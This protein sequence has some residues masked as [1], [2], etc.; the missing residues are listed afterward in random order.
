MRHVFRLGAIFLLFYLISCASVQPQKYRTC[1]RVI[2]GDTIELDHNEKVRL[3]GI[4]T[5]ETVDPRKPVQRFGIEAS[6]FTN[7]LVSGRAVRLEYDQDKSDKYFRT[8]AYVYLADGTFVNAEIIK[9]GF[10]FAYTKYPFKYLD[11]FRSLERE[12][13]E[14]QT[15]LWGDDNHTT[16]NITSATQEDEIVY[17][18][19]SGSKYHTETCS[20]LRKS[21]IPIKLK[22]AC[23]RGY[24]PCSRCD[25][26]PCSSSENEGDDDQDVTVY[27]TKSGSKYHTEACG[28]LRKTKIPIKLKD[29]C[30][31]GY[32]PCSRCSP[33]PCPKSEKEAGGAGRSQAPQID[34][35]PMANMRLIMKTPQKEVYSHALQ[36]HHQR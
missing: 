36:G 3:I 23:A 18:T 26:P 16:R 33:P 22:D 7:K 14:S 5:P 10:A 17:V 12:A 1:T 30:D 2:D 9:Q 32:S 4:D 25:P 6:E 21:K 27:I 20:S 31:R 8:L 11:K 34:R 13:R 15:G 35:T 24:S 19:K 28:Y 29:A